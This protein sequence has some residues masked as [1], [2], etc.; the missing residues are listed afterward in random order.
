MR[1]GMALYVLGLVLV[2]G[3]V[4]LVIAFVIRVGGS[5]PPSESGFWAAY[6]AA[7]V[8]LLGAGA[9]LV[10]RGLA[11]LGRARGPAPAPPDA[12]EPREA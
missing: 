7:I 6:L 5:L 12:D 10:S 1:T 2:T 8:G 4:E 9:V 3:G 11:M